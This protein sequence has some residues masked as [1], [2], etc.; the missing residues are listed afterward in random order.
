[1]LGE[2]KEN[3][4]GLVSTT[5]ESKRSGRRPYKSRVVPGSSRHLGPFKSSSL[6]LKVSLYL[7]K[8]RAGLF[9]EYKEELTETKHKEIK[10][11]VK[12]EERSKR[13]LFK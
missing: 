6:I 3:I 7:I 2:V 1:L 5:L 11:V 10:K 8:G 4:N 12:K 9:H 13:E